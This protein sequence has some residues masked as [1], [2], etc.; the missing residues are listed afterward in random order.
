MADHRH[1]AIAAYAARKAKRAAKQDENEWFWA[2]VS[3]EASKWCAGTLSS[4]GALGSA[5][6]QTLFY[7]AKEDLVRL[8]V[9]FAA[10]ERAL[11]GIQAGEQAMRAG[12]KVL[13]PLDTPPLMQ[14]LFASWDADK[15]SKSAAEDARTSHEPGS[16]RW[17][18]GATAVTTRPLDEVER[19]LA[20]WDSDSGVWAW[21]PEDG[22]P[23][24]PS[25]ESKGVK[26]EGKPSA[27][28]KGVKFEGAEQCK[29]SVESEGVKSEGDERRK[30]SV[31]SKGVKLEGA[32]Q[33]K[34]SVESEGVKS[35]V[36]ERRKPSLESTYVKSEGAEQCK[37]SVEFKGVKSEGEERR[38]PS[39]E[40]KGVA[41]SSA[42][43][44]GVKDVSAESSAMKAATD[45]EDV[46]AESSAMT[47][48]VKGVSAE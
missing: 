23:Q 34:P 43:T 30:P 15:A 24:Q 45:V 17:R 28:S 4:F 36:E 16:L 8:E 33:R 48:G 39:V 22:E 32:E 41:E 35:E 18:P 2:E 47:E 10:V 26:F 11:Q 44:E 20:G 19:S 38:K 29:P 3:A 25:V 7:A 46:S 9:S 40:S 13:A 31:E 6:L 42:M 1:R 5:E 12:E 21:T 27:E 14:E 37:P